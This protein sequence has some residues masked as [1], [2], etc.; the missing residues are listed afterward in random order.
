MVANARA[1]FRARL[2]TAVAA[3]LV[4]DALLDAI[5]GVDSQAPRIRR[6]V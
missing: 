3:E 1:D 6:A 4:G 2:T 5:R